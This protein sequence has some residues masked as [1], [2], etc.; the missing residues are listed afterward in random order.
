[1]SELASLEPLLG[2]LTAARANTDQY[3][4]RSTL[5]LP[6]RERMR[7]KLNY[8]AAKEEEEVVVRRVVS[9]VGGTADT[10]LNPFQKVIAAKVLSHK[11]R[12]PVPQSL[13]LI[14]NGFRTFDTVEEDVERNRGTIAIIS[15]LAISLFTSEGRND[16]S[17]VAIN[18][19]LGRGGIYLTLSDGMS[20]TIPSMNEASFPDPSVKS[21]GYSQT[22]LSTGYGDNIAEQLKT[23]DPSSDEYRLPFVRLGTP[24]KQI[25]DL[26]DYVQSPEA[27][28]AARYLVRYLQKDSWI[29][30]EEPGD[31]LEAK[32]I[33]E[34]SNV[35][36][37]ILFGL[38]PRDEE[39]HIRGKHSPMS[40]RTHVSTTRT[41]NKGL[42]TYNAKEREALLYA[43]GTT[44]SDIE[45]ATREKIARIARE[46]QTAA[47][48]AGSLRAE[49]LID[50]FFEQLS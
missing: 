44:P 37:D 26:N 25:G 30:V 20:V 32:V 29:H 3:G 7:N 22:L 5:G 18:E 33:D 35:Y 6:E 27:R 4:N 42:A 43:A 12:T 23:F 13:E 41:R 38:T 21:E 17:A 47:R 14:A 9:G 34:V 16:L 1:M 39:K 49:Q 46:A 11:W 45:A 48:V 8:E 15:E 31:E 36:A 2:E 24:E 40:Q 28:F 50:P 10:V 19:R